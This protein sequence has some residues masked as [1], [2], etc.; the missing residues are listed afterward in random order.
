VAHYSNIMAAIG[1]MLVI[2]DHIITLQRERRYVW[3][4]RKT[5]PCIL[6]FI[7]RYGMTLASLW[8]TFELVMDTKLRQVSTDILYLMAPVVVLT[9]G[10]NFVLRTYAIY[11]E[12]SCALA[13]L[14]PIFCGEMATVLVSIFLILI[15]KQ[16]NSSTF[17][18]ISYEI[19]CVS[20]Y[21]CPGM[22]W[23][24]TSPRL[25]DVTLYFGAVLCFETAVFVLTLGRAVLDIA[26]A[27]ETPKRTLLRQITM[28]GTLYFIGT[29]TIN[30]ISLIQIWFTPIVN[31]AAVIVNIPFATSLA[32]V[33]ISRL[34]INLREAASHSR[35]Q[36]SAASDIPDNIFPNLHIAT[37]LGSANSTSSRRSSGRSASSTLSRVMGLDD[38]QAILPPIV[39]EP[40]EVLEALFP[41]E[42]VDKPSEETETTFLLFSDKPMEESPLPYAHFSGKEVV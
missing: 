42:D 25:S 10:I 4:E 16:R 37:R 32:S 35:R 7:C 36:Y 29:F 28:D 1:S 34:F 38:F 11:G 15:R 20:V 27:P 2:Y 6:F 13:F 26:F 8:G 39:H 17:Q 24:E 18:T 30:G 12:A 22:N 9:T 41:S 40:W 33:L 19:E 31:G 3:G 14:L 21:G 23:A 5:L